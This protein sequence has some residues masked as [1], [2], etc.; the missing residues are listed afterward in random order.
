MNLT[1]FTKIKVTTCSRLNW[2]VDN[3]L[4]QIYH[5]RAVIIN[6]LSFVDCIPPHKQMIRKQ[7]IQHAR[8]YKAPLTETKQ[9]KYIIDNVFPEKSLIITFKKSR[10]K[11]GTSRNHKLQPNMSYVA[12]RLFYLFKY[13]S[14]SENFNNFLSSNLAIMQWQ[15]F[16]EFSEGFLKMIAKRVGKS[17]IVIT[18]LSLAFDNHQSVENRNTCPRRRNSIAKY[19]LKISIYSKS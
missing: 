18:R 1:Y 15:D 7:T 8:L 3:E 9:I 11:M 4:S 10:Y 13:P 16:S 19:M 14:V 12:R 6:F 17:S 5:L 2:N